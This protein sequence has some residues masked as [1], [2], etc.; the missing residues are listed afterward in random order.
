MNYKHCLLAALGAITLLSTGCKKD[1]KYNYAPDDPRIRVMRVGGLNATFVVNDAEHMIFNYDSLEYGTDVSALIPYFSGYD[2]MPTIEILQ[3]GEWM[4][5]GNT[6]YEKQTFDLS[7]LQIRSTSESGNFTTEYTVNVRVHQ[8]DVN[9][10]DWVNGEKMQGDSLSVLGGCLVGDKMYF[11]V[12]DSKNGDSFISSADAKS[13]SSFVP[14]GV[15]D[16]DLS[17]AI[18]VGEQTLAVLSKDGNVY[19]IDAATSTVTKKEMGYKLSKLLFTVGDKVWA[20]SS[21]TLVAMDT[22]FNVVSSMKAPAAFPKQIVNTLVTKSGVRFDLGYVYGL[23]GDKAVLCAID[24]RGNV[25]NITTS[26][27][28]LPAYAKASLV[29]IDNEMCLVGGYDANGVLAVSF[30]TSANGGISWKINTH[31][32]LPKDLQSANSLAALVS[33]DKLYLLGETKMMVATVRGAQ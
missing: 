14:D 6:A 16:M 33:N 7:K 12:N 9:A 11:A 2:A 10:L 3:N 22:D 20:V 30:A 19:T 18:S 13:W 8:F 5:Y 24:E 26:D 32:C 15:E 25:S 29:F 28:G 21:D 27:K 1:D 23:N 31:K 4:P 17:S